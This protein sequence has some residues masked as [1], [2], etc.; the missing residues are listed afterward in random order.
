MGCKEERILAEFKKKNVYKTDT[1]IVPHWFW[2]W[3][4]FCHVYY[5]VVLRGYR[6]SVLETTNHQQLG[7]KRPKL[8]VIHVTAKAIHERLVIVLG[9]YS[10]TQFVILPTP[11]PLNQQ[12]FLVSSV[13]VQVFSKSLFK[14]EICLNPVVIWWSPSTLCISAH[15]L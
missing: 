10:F 9:P 11:P 4:W 15:S 5:L 7:S 13:F 3:F 6:V 1:L 14:I 12:R 2:F 8:S